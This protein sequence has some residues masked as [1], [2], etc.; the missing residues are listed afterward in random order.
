MLRIRASGKKE[1]PPTRKLR[2]L[3][4][5]LCAVVILM[6][7]TGIDTTKKSTQKQDQEREIAASNSQINP[8]TSDQDD[9][10]AT[11][12]NRGS[13]EDKWTMMRKRPREGGTLQD[14]KI[15]RAKIKQEIKAA[16]SHAQDNK[17]AADARGMF[18]IKEGATA[19]LPNR[20]AMVKVHGHHLPLPSPGGEG[21]RKKERG[22]FLPSGMPTEP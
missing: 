7:L 5:F 20:D 16:R 8:T 14:T 6:C 13:S 18:F 1:A 17:D 12:S 11:T 10:A 21:L 22:F 3:R 19:L 15:F 2:H 9:V 4:V